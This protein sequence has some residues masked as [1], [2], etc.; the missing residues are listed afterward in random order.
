MKSETHPAARSDCEEWPHMCVRY[1]PETYGNTCICL[2]PNTCLHKLLQIRISV[3][4]GGTLTRC[5]TAGFRSG[6]DNVLAHLRLYAPY[7]DRCLQTFRYSVRSP[8]RISCS[9]LGDCP[10]TSYMLWSFVLKRAWVCK[11]DFV[12]TNHC[13][14]SVFSWRF[15]A[16]QQVTHS[17]TRILWAEEHYF[18]HRVFSESFESCTVQIHKEYVR[19]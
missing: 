17:N 12:S 5:D 11:F 2:V 3:F 10:R 8:R 9:T 4:Y 18:S 6:A 14:L 13:G 15:M 16:K 7:V 1:C 19:V